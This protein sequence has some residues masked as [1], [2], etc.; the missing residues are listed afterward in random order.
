MHLTRYLKE[1]RKRQKAV[2]G[3]D[4][5]DSTELPIRLNIRLGSDKG[6]LEAY[7]TARGKRVGST[8]IHYE[9]NT[10]WER[11]QSTSSDEEAAD[12]VMKSEGRRT[13]SSEE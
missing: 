4:E 2:E 13:S 8:T 5:E 3:W 9:G 7:A 6:V 1:E 11:A 10:V 12:T